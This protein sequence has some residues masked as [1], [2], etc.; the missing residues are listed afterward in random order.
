MEIM[1]NVALLRF[2]IKDKTAV[3]YKY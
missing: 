2:E 1:H 3:L